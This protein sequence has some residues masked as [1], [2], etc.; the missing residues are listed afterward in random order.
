MMPNSE[1]QRTTRKM[2]SNTRYRRKKTLMQKTLMPKIILL[3]LGFLPLLSADECGYHASLVGKE[4]FYL[5]Q[6]FQ[7]NISI[8]LQDY[9]S[10]FDEI[11]AYKDLFVKQFS[12]YST[13]ARLDS[14]E[15]YPLIPFTEDQNLIHIKE[16]IP[17]FRASRECSLRNAQLVR[18]TNLTKDKIKQVLIDHGIPYVPFLGIGYQSSVYTPNQGFEFFDTPP[19]GSKTILKLHELSLPFLD[20]Q[21]NIAYPPT[22]DTSSTP[23]IGTTTISPVGKRSVTTFSPEDNDVYK[24]QVLC[25]KTN[26]PWDLLRNRDSWFKLYNKVSKTLN[27]LS[28]AIPKFGSVRNTL[29]TLPS[30]ANS[31][32][33]LIK[34][35]APTY[36]KNIAKVL[37]TFSTSSPWEKANFSVLD[38]FKNLIKDVKKT[39]STLGRSKGMLTMT[40]GNPSFIISDVDESNWLGK[41]NLDEDVFGIAGPI[42]VEPVGHSI[43]AS[44]VV[45]RPTIQPIVNNGREDSLSNAN[46]EIDNYVVNLNLKIYDRINDKLSKY[47]VR[48]N[49]IKNKVTTATHVV[50]TKK[51][52][53]ALIRQPSL[54]NCFRKEEEAYPICH[55]LD[56]QKDLGLDNFNKAKSISC[57][58]SLFSK[59][60]DPKFLECPLADA[61]ETTLAY[62][63]HCTLQEESSDDIVDNNMAAIVSSTKPISLRLMCDD[64]SKMDAKSFEVSNFPIQISTPCE[65]QEIKEDTSV[66]LL[67]QLNKDFVQNQFST[68]ILTQ[69]PNIVKPSFNFPWQHPAAMPITIALSISIPILVITI[70]ATALTC[71]LT[72][73]PFCKP[74][75]KRKPSL[76]EIPLEDIKPVEVE[77]FLEEYALTR[78]LPD[79]TRLS[80][81]LNRTS[82]PSSRRNSFSRQYP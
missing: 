59:D 38:T 30:K 63:A 6:P 51:S 78:G 60:Y 76:N 53:Y 24:S 62:R 37:K 55:S 47:L 7:K 66:T 1:N 11:T 50:R 70:F 18:I 54:T 57:G 73:T 34:I 33:N 25:A 26:N 65:V 12:N 67:P 19:S 56:F 69:T 71:I 39:V 68:E 14:L 31:V 49:I 82:R 40:E 36:L 16:E 28:K 9:F 79:Y 22:T 27:T 44:K 43:Q 13:N 3:A 64:V 32:L 61:P 23:T 41:L 42:L 80:N 46:V 58:N 48:P 45:S 21:G 5:T 81:L 4:D 74:K 17:S 10:T 72:K 75:L 29:K 8:D 35:Q 52:S 77:R 2:K 20:M 15:P